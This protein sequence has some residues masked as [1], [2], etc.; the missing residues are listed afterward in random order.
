MKRATDPE[1]RRAIREEQRRQL[2]E[3]LRVR[4]EYL[5]LPKRKTGNHVGCPNRW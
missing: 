2:A 1:T 5:Q 3:L 4:R